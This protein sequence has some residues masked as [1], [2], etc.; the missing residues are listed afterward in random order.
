MFFLLRSIIQL[1]EVMFLIYFE[2]KVIG[3][4]VIQS[5][6][7]TFREIGYS[8][9]RFPLTVV[10]LVVF[11]FINGRMIEGAFEE[12]TQLLFTVL[13][14]AMTSTIGQLVY[15]RFYSSKSSRFII[16]GFSIGLTL[17]YY[18]LLNSQDEIEQSLYIRTSVVLFALFITFIWI[19]SLRNERIYFHQNFLS[20]F[21]AVAITFLFTSVLALG[22]VLII[23]A[24]DFLLFSMDDNLLSHLLNILVSLFA[25]VY[26][27][28][29]TPDF[30]DDEPKASFMNVSVI[31]ERMITFV[32]IPLLSVYTVVLILYLLINIRQDFWMDNLLEPLLVS[33]TL[34]GIIIVLLASNLSN[35]VSRVFLKIF[36]KIFLPVV[37][38]QTI[39]SLL[40]IREMGITHGRYYVIM[41]GI[42]A[43]AAGIIFSFNRPKNYGWLA[44]ILIVL[45]GISAIPP[46][47]A[48]TVSK[49]NQIN[50]LEEKLVEANLLQNN[51]L[52][53]NKE[54]SL[55]DREAIT[56]LVTYLAGLGYTDELSYLPKDFEVYKD[57]DETFGFTMTY[58]RDNSYQN[59]GKFA[60]LED[61]YSMVQY[62]Q[63]EDMF[64]RQYGSFNKEDKNDLLEEISFTIDQEYTVIRKVE[65]QKL[66]LE[67]LDADNQSLIIVDATEVFDQVFDDRANVNQTVNLNDLED[68]SFVEENERVKLRF[69]VISI[70]DTPDYYSTDFYLFIDI[71]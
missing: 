35:R 52:I 12:Y 56:E 4:R 67:V 14:G 17:I 1:E 64:T 61:E 28:S 62:I 30:T 20:T 43:I 7:N 60:Y 55:E 46:V 54:V 19:P 48:F 69:V 66:V 36:P 33:Y 18:L 45:A 65:N 16:M 22:I 11:T 51:Q 23:Q 47:D 32:L 3:M 53:P 5:F 59:N 49:K 31:L 6:Q 58:P 8:I 44:A 42:F 29:M 2:R 15:E 41:F 25:P 9:R 57:F 40:K 34:M 38:F 71:K 37:I 50:L 10:F 13:V 39:S 24:I 26:F 70:E 21:K 27:L 63:E 68:A